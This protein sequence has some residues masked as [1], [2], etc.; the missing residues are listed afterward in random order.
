LTRRQ[1]EQ[2]AY[3]KDLSLPDY[4]KLFYEQTNGLTIES[5]YFTDRFDEPSELFIHRC[6]D[7]V[8]T[9]KKV[10]RLPDKRFIL[11]AGDQDQVEFLFDTKN[12]DPRGHPLICMSLPCYG[13][14]VPLTNSFDVFL[15]CAC[16]GIFGLLSTFIIRKDECESLPDTPKKMLKK[17]KRVLQLLKELFTTTKRELDLLPLWHLPE[18]AQAMIKRSMV[19]WL[20]II[21]QLVKRFS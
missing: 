4:F 10:N 11:F 12:F 15:E 17:Q 20:Q 1:I 7:L 3:F 19:Q 14:C 16:L 9:T 21:K 13:Y 18:K 6:D 5:Y 2:L 8:F